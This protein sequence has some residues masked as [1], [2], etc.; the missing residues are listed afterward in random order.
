MH[1]GPGT[2]GHDRTTTMLSEQAQFVWEAGEYH[3]GRV[4]HYVPALRA[5]LVRPDYAT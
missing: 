2:R 5:F 4:I 3:L 1:L